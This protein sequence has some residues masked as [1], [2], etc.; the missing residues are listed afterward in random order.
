M[1][2]TI[3]GFSVGVTVSF[4]AG[5]HIWLL[6]TNRTTLEMHGFSEGF[7]AFGGENVKENFTQICGDQFWYYL[8]PV[9]RDTESQGVRYPVR[10]RNKEGVEKY[11]TKNFII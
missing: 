3:A 7:N 5:F 10:L 8:L 6:A 1:I 4:L 2:G 9:E 11:H